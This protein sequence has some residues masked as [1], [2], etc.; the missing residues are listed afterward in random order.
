MGQEIEVYFKR[1]QQNLELFRLAQSYFKGYICKY[2]AV[3]AIGQI[4]M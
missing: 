1:K 4:E 2:F 3:K